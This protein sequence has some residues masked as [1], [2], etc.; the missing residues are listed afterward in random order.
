MNELKDKVNIT[1]FVSGGGTNLQ[2]I[3]DNVN[4][5]YLDKA[6]IVQVISSNCNAY[7]LQ[8][9]KDSGINGVCIGKDQWPD[10]EQQYK[11]IIQALKSTNTDLIVLAGYMKILQPRLINLYKDRII[12]IHPSLIPK[13]CGKGF[14]GQRVHDA[15][16]TSGEMFTGATVHFVDEGVDTGRIILQEK[17]NVEEND[18]VESL[19]ARV[20]EAEHRILPK[21]IKLFCDRKI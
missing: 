18:T 20:L 11:A 9:A 16:L 14:Y 5:G 13:F 12:N 3:I 2:A 6:E 15:V 19:A 10:E 21:A 8:R 1:V 7:A 4:N 17:V